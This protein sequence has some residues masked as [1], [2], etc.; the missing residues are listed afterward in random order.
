[1]DPTDRNSIDSKSKRL[2]T[3]AL[4][5]GVYAA[6]IA[7]SLWFVV[8][9]W[10]FLGGGETGYLL[11]VVSGFIGVVIALQLIL[12]RVTRPSENSNQ[13]TAAADAKY[14][15]SLRDWLR[16]DFDIQEG[17][18][19]STEAAIIIILPIAAAA[20]GMMAFGIEFQIVEHA[21]V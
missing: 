3:T 7:L 2:V 8:W 21:G 18:L 10:S 12:S 9:V 20:I 1:M 15:P 6:L 4:H 14:A 16:G 13:N 5:P 17:P 19:R 11:F